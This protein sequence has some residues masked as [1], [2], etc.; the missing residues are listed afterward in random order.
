MASVVDVVFAEL[1][2]AE[3]KFPGWP[4]DIVHAVAIV[5]EE[6]GEAIQAALEVYYQNAPKVRV[7][8][9]LVQ[10]TAM[11]LRALF[12]LSKECNE[13]PQA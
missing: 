9:E 4:D 11:G 7:V 2:Y 5:A 1:R 12:A 10:T 3:A 13:V 6:T 8:E